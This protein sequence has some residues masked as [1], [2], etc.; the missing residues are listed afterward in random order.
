MERGLE[1]LQAAGIVAL[2]LAI[3][4][5]CSRC[6]SAP[7][8]PASQKIDAVIKSGV[9]DRA[10]VVTVDDKTA[11]KSALLQARDSVIDAEAA[12]I[13]AEQK[14][15]KSAAWASRGKWLFGGVAVSAGLIL[16]GI[17]AALVRRFIG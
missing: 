3:A 8:V 16:L 9:L 5:A 13:E 12:K 2:L 6:S 17:G 1:I 4:V 7:V 15:E 10:H 14:A 11:I